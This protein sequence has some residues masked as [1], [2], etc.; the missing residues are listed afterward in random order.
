MEQRLRTFRFARRA[1]TPHSPTQNLSTIALSAQL[2]HTVMDQ[3]T[4]PRL[5]LASKIVLQAT[6][7]LRA[8]PSVIS[9]HASQATSTQ[10]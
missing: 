1:L 4:S 3:L 9:S 2:A 10:I 5:Q 7:V 8:L 6:T